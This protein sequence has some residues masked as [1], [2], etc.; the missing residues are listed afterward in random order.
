MSLANGA[1]Y[2]N[3]PTEGTLAWAW[4]RR[5]TVALTVALVFGAALGFRLFRLGTWSFWGDELVTFYDGRMILSQHYWNPGPYSPPHEVFIHAA[6]IG[7]AILGAWHRVCDGSEFA[8]RLPVAVASALAVAAV[9]VLAW[10]SRGGWVATALA[11]LLIPWPWHLFH[12]QNHRVYSFVYVFGAVGCVLADAGFAGR[13]GRKIAAAGIVLTLAALTHNVAGLM[14]GLMIGWHAVLVLTDRANWPVR[15]LAWQ[16]PAVAG[17]VVNAILFRRFTPDYPV[18]LH[19]YTPA[20][21]AMSMA[22]NIG[23][24]VLLAA[25]AGAAWAVVARRRDLYWNVAAA[26]GVATAAVCVPM[27]STFRP[28]YLFA[29]TAP[30]HILAA[31][32]I[33]EA[34]RRTWSMHRA[35]S[36]GV[37]AAVPL[38]TA[39]SVLSYYVDGDRPDF[40]GAAEWLRA[41]V[42]PGD[43]VW[44]NQ[45]M[46]VNHYLGM[47]AARSYPKQ[48]AAEARDILNR[49]GRVW[50]VDSF[51]TAGVDPRK[52]A[53]LR[54]DFRLQTV[55]QRTR[56]DYHQ[57]G[58]GVWLAGHPPG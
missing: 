15:S 30:V 46:N 26:G 33:A 58:I 35:L 4:R 6:P 50:V 11:L 49:N 19:W 45:C 52:L 48:P 42:R 13:S 40:R 14:L 18:G 3:Y 32:G 43:V 24:P 27:I 38:L 54:D 34:A 53:W 17:L 55:I 16:A 28:D 39:P 57:N 10:R 36:A 7:W 41:Q 21:C 2:V 8:V 23:L 12:A 20:G 37:L 25:G 51:S 31:V 22:F 5:L 56:Y 29:L 44:S 47:Q 1:I 9:V